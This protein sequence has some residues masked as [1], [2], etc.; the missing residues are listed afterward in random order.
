MT[1][2]NGS[3]H[4]AGIMWAKTKRDILEAIRRNQPA[5]YI[6]FVASTC[7]VTGLRKET[8]ERYLQEM[9]DAGLIR[10]DRKNRLQLEETAEALLGFK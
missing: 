2:F 9:R 6:K 5:P 1:K 4:G 8:V 3:A 10:E 7:F